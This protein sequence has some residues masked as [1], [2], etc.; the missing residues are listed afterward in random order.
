MGPTGETASRDFFTHLLDGSRS[1]NRLGWQW[2]IGSGAAKAYGFSQSQ[3]RRPAPG[4]CNACAHL[5]SCPI[6]D[7]PYEPPHTL[8]DADPRLRSDPDIERS[9]GP[10]HA[11]LRSEPEAVWLTAQS[12]GDDDPALAAHPLMGAGCRSSRSESRRCSGP[13]WRGEFERYG[14]PGGRRFVVPRR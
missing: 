5:H 10:E 3:V 1:A 6:R 8:V 7:W 9:A 11:D 13:K 14:M 12:L 4:L 2:T